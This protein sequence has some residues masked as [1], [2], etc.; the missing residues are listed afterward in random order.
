[1]DVFGQKQMQS[2]AILRLIKKKRE[3]TQ[4]KRREGTKKIGTAFKNPD[5]T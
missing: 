4:L 5:L 2:R 1:M 3:R